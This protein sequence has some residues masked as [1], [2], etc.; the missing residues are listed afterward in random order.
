MPNERCESWS[1]LV[2]APL[3]N[4]KSGVDWNLIEEEY[5]QKILNRL[6]E[7]GLKVKDRLAYFEYRS[8]RNL[9]IEVNAPGGSIYGTSSNGFLAPF[10]RPQ[11]RSDIPG[12]YLVG[13]STHPG[14]GLPLVGISAEIVAEAIG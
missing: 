14:G 5:A 9:A 12:L 4:P 3:H 11:N 10:K 1:V 13:G 8:P 2:N 6:E 7:L